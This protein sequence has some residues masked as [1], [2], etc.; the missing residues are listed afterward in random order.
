MRSFVPEVLS[1]V[2]RKIENIATDSYAPYWNK[3]FLTLTWGCKINTGATL[4][5]EF[6]RPGI[7]SYFTQMTKSPVSGRTPLSEFSLVNLVDIWWPFS[8]FNLILGR[9][10]TFFFPLTEYFIPNLRCLVYI[11][12]AVK[13]APLLFNNNNLVNQGFFKPFFTF[14]KKKKF[15]VF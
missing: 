4:N 8:A 6:H 9:K 3:H 11:L 10:E 2:Y 12:S 13:I 14:I 15:T 1:L 7:Y 5:H